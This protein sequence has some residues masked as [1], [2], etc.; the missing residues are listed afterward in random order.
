MGPTYQAKIFTSSIFFSG[1]TE[2]IILTYVSIK[3]IQFKQSFFNNLK[4]K[5]HLFTVLVNKYEKGEMK[6]DRM[7]TPVR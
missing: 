1:H 7:T 3:E 2:M 5:T 4:V 6:F